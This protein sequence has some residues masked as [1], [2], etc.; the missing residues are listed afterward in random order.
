MKAKS[1]TY[2]PTYI[3]GG[4]GLC[5]IHVAQNPPLLGEPEGAFYYTYKDHLGSILK[6]TNSDV[7]Q[8]WEQSFDAWGRYRDPN[9]WEVYDSTPSA[10]GVFDPDVIDMPP[11]FNRGYTGHEHLRE[12]DLINMNGRL[13]DPIPGRMLSADNYV[14]EPG[15]SQSYNRYAY[16]FNNPLKYTDPNGEFGILAA[17]GVAA[18]AAAV[19]YFINVARND[20]EWNPNNWNSGDAVTFGFQH[21][22]GGSTNYYGGGNF[23]N[24]SGLLGM[25]SS[26]GNFGGGLS[27]FGQAS[28][29]QMPS[30]GTGSIN[31]NN[32]NNQRNWDIANHQFEGL[33]GY[34]PPEE[35]A[36]SIETNSGMSYG[37]A[38]TMFLLGLGLTIDWS[39]KGASL[40]QGQNLA[41]RTAAIEHNMPTGNIDGIVNRTSKF[42][43]SMKW[44]GRG[45][46]VYGAAYSG[47]E[48]YNAYRNGDVAGFHRAT[49]DFGMGL[50][51]AAMGGIPGVIIYG[52]YMMIMSPSPE[53][54]PI[55]SNPTIFLND[56]TFVSPTPFI[57][58]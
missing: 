30:A 20:G 58:Y 21:N 9:T 6:L 56:N 49:L 51:T 44:L 24:T 26:T 28:Y 3:S 42:S 16:A 55:Y 27:T 33:G 48:G 18:A 12:F 43:S 15:N 38:Q 23:G 37:D 10:G 36:V 32:V 47:Y 14:Q 41:I 11:W 50:G 8:E 53:R 34:Y 22:V 4:D 45:A 7:S 25:N 35:L 19:S 29:N 40:F 13:Y 46:I 54:M 39:K 57:D 52:G 5:A 2:N 1:D 17:L 31:W